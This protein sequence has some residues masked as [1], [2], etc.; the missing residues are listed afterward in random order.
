MKTLF[1][2]LFIGISLLPGREGNS[3]NFLKHE[4]YRFPVPVNFGQSKFIT[5]DEFDFNCIESISF[6]F[7]FDFLEN[8]NAG[9]PDTINKLPE[10][11]YEYCCSIPLLIP[12]L[13]DLPPPDLV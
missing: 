1:V 6:E 12:Q 4:Y 7:E 10:L 2:I 9:L 13:F 11:Y 5:E 8:N 3:C